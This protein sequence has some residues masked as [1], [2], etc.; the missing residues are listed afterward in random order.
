MGKKN[1]KRKTKKIEIN[2]KYN[3]ETRLLN[4]NRY[5]KKRLAGKKERIC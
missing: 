1:E 4:S 2:I 5:S 3:V